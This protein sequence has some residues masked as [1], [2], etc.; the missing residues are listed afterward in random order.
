MYASQNGDFGRTA[1]NRPAVPSANDDQQKWMVDGASG[2]PTNL[3]ALFF[4]D[5]TAALGAVLTEG[6]EELTNRAKAARLRDAIKNIAD[7]Q[8]NLVLANN[9]VNQGS[10][11]D[12]EFSD[13][14]P[15]V[16]DGANK[17][18]G[19]KWIG[20]D[21]QGGNE[22][23][24]DGLAWV[25]TKGAILAY[26][27]NT[28]GARGKRLAE[29]GA[30]VFQYLRDKTNRTAA[31]D[32]RWTDFSRMF[33]S[34]TKLLTPPD[35]RRRIYCHGTDQTFNAGSDRDSREK[36]LLGSQQKS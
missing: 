20:K 13:R 9:R 16:G 5:L 34:K 6:Q 10:F 15:V 12:A 1:D 2:N 8:A 22:W 21:A 28:T 19:Y 11:A 23:T 25:Q 29:T 24:W 26:D 17:Q 18:R 32:L 7:R 4:N 14:L 31:S 33:H 36:S 35:Q 30:A 27:R 3:A